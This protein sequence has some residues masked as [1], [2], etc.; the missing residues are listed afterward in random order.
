MDGPLTDAGFESTVTGIDCCQ[1][2]PRH[3]WKTFFVY[4]GQPFRDHNIFCNV[5]CSYWPFHNCIHNF[6]RTDMYKG[7]DVPS[8][9]IWPKHIFVQKYLAEKYS[10]EKKQLARI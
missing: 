8:R 4:G 5:I 10:A 9:N 2:P 6:I 7:I 1:P 3:Q